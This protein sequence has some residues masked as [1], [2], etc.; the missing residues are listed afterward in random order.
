MSAATDSNSGLSLTPRLMP[1]TRNLP[2]TENVPAT[3]ASSRSPGKPSSLLPVGALR[4]CSSQVHSCSH[5]GWTVPGTRKGSLSCGQS[6]QGLVSPKAGCLGP[7]PIAGQPPCSA[8]GW[9]AEA[10]PG[11]SICL[12]RISSFVTGLYVHEPVPFQLWLEAQGTKNW[13]NSHYLITLSQNVTA[14][15]N[16]TILET[17]HSGIF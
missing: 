6:F 13:N 10:Y 17:K 16:T 4:P 14:V 7:T 11:G 9:G 15:G 8:L 1:L 3:P 12:M 5:R 2:L